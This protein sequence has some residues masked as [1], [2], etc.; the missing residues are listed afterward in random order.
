MNKKGA[1]NTAAVIEIGTNNIA[2][3][4]AQL[5]KGEIRS[6]DYLNTL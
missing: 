5:V 1:A 6:L 4:V 2:M 3:R